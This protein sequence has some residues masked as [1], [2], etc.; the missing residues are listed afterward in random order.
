MNTKQKPILSEK[1]MDYLLV[2]SLFMSA[3]VISKTPAEI[4]LSYVP[5]F[6]LLPILIA[7]Y[8]IPKLVLKVFL[9]IILMGFIYIEL[10][11]NTWAQ[12]TKIAVGF[13]TSI[14]FFDLIIQ[15][16]NFDLKKLFK[17]YM[18]ACYIIAIIGIVQLISFHLGIRPLYNFHWILNKWGLSQGGLGIRVNSIF[19]EPSY[20]A[21]SI[22][23]AMFVSLYNLTS[24]KQYFISS[25]KSIAILILYFISFS[26]LG[27]F[28][29]FT[30]IIFLFVK[31]GF[32]TSA[33]LAGPVLILIFT[34]A[35]NTIGEFKDRVDGTFEMFS[36]QNIYSYDIHGSSF[37]LYNNYHVAK[38]NFLE[39]PLFGS[40]LGSQGHAFEKHSLTNQI[41]AVNIE[42]NSADANSLFLRLLSETGIF[43]LG[44]FLI[45]LFKHYLP[46]KRAMSEEYW[47]ISVGCLIIIILH[48]VRQ[49][50]YFYN[51]FPFFIWLYYYASKI[52]KE[53][54]NL[55]NE[56]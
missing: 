21:A 28:G 11:Q 54:L 38:T 30:A 2:I 39:N 51:G 36:T 33:L 49:G 52:S 16:Y 48:L 50:H 55:A 14:L 32:I 19:S 29:F 34:L 12:F 44:F 18:N 20:V 4:Y 7:K 6:L 31:R 35:Y 9:P 53:K 1:A 41:G 47:L 17:V 26:S 22:A 10:G 13:F 27:I 45:F 37:V 23:P 56:K 8:G 15:Q 5:M 40:G 43:G 46:A 3:Y 42:S 24:K 25:R